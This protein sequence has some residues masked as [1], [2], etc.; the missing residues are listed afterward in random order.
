MTLA[1]QSD[2]VFSSLSPWR[3]ISLRRRDDFATIQLFVLR[4]MKTALECG[5]S[6]SDMLTAAACELRGGARRDLFKLVQQ[7]RSGVSLATAC[8]Q[9]PSLLDDET[10]LAIRVGEQLG[11]LPAALSELVSLQHNRCRARAFHP[12]SSRFY[13]MSV[14][15]VYLI[16]VS[17]ILYFIAPTFKKMLDEFEMPSPAPMLLVFRVADIAAGYWPLILFAFVFFAISILSPRTER[18]IFSRFRFLKRLS[19]FQKPTGI[20]NHVLA[21]AI[22]QQKSIHKTLSILAKYHFQSATRQKLLVARNDMELGTECW[23][24]IESAGLL[25]AKE[26]KFLCEQKDNRD[27]AYFL[28]QLAEKSWQVQDRMK[29]LRSL[30]INPA[31]TLVFGVFVGMFCIG[32]FAALISLITALA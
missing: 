31:L 24:A 18:W 13:W 29:S 21:N 3:A 9:F 7:L 19:L 27:H 2:F 25:N 11:I 23:S 30:L 28:K 5:E 8:E 4:T 14:A 15:Y 26:T 32:F 12:V 16:C 20:T 1:A 17:F 6:P 10:V 22:G